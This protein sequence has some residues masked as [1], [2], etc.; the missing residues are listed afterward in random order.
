VVHGLGI[1]RA[2]LWQIRPLVDDGRVQIVFD[3]HET[4]K[5]PIYAVS[6]PTNLPSAKT[7][8]FIEVLAAQLERARL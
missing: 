5:I 3:D 6:F 1:G 4:A 2:P 8:L 7:R